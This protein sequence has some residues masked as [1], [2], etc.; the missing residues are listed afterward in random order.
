MTYERGA[1]HVF[2]KSGFKVESVYLRGL[3]PRASVKRDKGSTRVP[4]LQKAQ[5]SLRKYSRAQDP[6][7]WGAAEKTT[8]PKHHLEASLRLT[9]H[10]AER[11]SFTDSAPEDTSTSDDHVQSPHLGPPGTSTDHALPSVQLSPAS[12]REQTAGPHPKGPPGTASRQQTQ[13]HT[14][15]R[16]RQSPALVPRAQ[17]PVS[18]RNRSLVIMKH[19]IKHSRCG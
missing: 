12:P 7:P 2:K 14:R 8:R 19:S 15:R 16:S 18:S 10:L 13:E 3:N 9:R 11:T 17:C 5:R 6:S 4:S 1:T